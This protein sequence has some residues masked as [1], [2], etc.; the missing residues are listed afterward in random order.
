M[1]YKKTLFKQNK[2][3]KFINNSL[4]RK[5]I[6][7]KK[8][9]C[10]NNDATQVKIYKIKNIDDFQNLL[11]YKKNWVDNEI[12]WFINKRDLSTY[13]F[14]TNVDIIACNF[15][16][17]IISMYENIS[18]NST[19]NYLPKTKNIWVCEVGRIKNWKLKI[20]DELSTNYN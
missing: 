7:Y 8:R 13:F 9:L 16:R 19:I 11:F 17:K 1:I 2:I 4:M 20:G 5:T 6:F 18:P 14:K 3:N 15:E 12:Y 10:I